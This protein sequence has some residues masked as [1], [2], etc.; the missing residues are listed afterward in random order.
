MFYSNENAVG[1][2]VVLE[3][4]HW[5]EKGV[6]TQGHVMR[7][8]SIKRMLFVLEDD[9]GELVLPVSGFHLLE[10]PTPATPALTRAVMNEVERDCVEEYLKEQGLRMYSAIKIC[11]GTQQCPGF[12]EDALQAVNGIRGHCRFGGALT[13]CSRSDYQEDMGI[14]REN[15]VKTR[16]KLLEESLPTAFPGVRKTPAGVFVDLGDEKDRP[17]YCSDDDS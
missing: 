8:K 12:R 6:Y 16:K 9:N 11:H 10:E 5:T 3:H 4:E 17:L 14:W 13:G 1:K 15:L 2:K 7:I